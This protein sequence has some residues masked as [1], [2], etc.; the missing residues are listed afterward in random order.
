MSVSNYQSPATAAP[1]N[2]VDEA[3][4]DSAF[5]SLRG[6]LAST[7]AA[8]ASLEPALMAAFRKHHAGGANVQ[9]VAQWFAPGMALAACIGMS[10]WLL[11]LHSRQSACRVYRQPAAMPIVIRRS[12]PC[13]R[14]N[15]SRWNPRPVWSAPRCRGCGLHPTACRSIRKTRAIR[16]APK[17]WSVP[18]GNR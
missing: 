13:N 5:K 6:A 1:L 14:S 2:A 11:L 17:C 9:W 4:L 3:R 12:L 16:C 15:K 18:M 10:A 7:T 8:P